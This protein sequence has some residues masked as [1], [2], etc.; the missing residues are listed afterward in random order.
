[1]TSMLRAGGRRHI[2]TSPY[3]GAAAA[4]MDTA[5]GICREQPVARFSRVL[6]WD[7]GNGLFD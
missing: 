4:M 7:D 2:R 6:S 3:L 5:T 1:M